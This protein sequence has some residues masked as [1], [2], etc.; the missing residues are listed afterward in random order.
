VE[1]SR[2]LAAAHVKA[3]HSVSYADAFAI[4][5][6]QEMQPQIVTRGT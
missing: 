5:L 4:A 1:R 2:T 6:A 3:H